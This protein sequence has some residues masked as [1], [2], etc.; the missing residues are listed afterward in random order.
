MTD[1]ID[2]AARR[3]LLG[4]IE[5][6]IRECQK[7]IK[8]VLAHLDEF[9]VDVAT[10]FHLDRLESY[11]S[12]L[13]S[14][15]SLVLGGSR[16]SGAILAFIAE[17][18][19]E[20]VKRHSITA[21][22]S[23]NLSLISRKIV[24]RSAETGEHYIARDWRDFREMFKQALGGGF[25]TAFTTLIKFGV[26]A[27]SL[28]GF[29]GGFLS[30]INYSLSFLVIQQLGFTLATKQPAMTG[31]AL[32]N[33][34]QQIQDDEG[35]KKL[36]D[37]I[38]HLIRSQMAAVMGNILAVIPAT[39]AVAWAYLE[40]TDRSLLSQSV[41]RYTIDSFSLLGPTPIYAA[42]TGV[43]LWCSSIMAGWADNWFARHRLLPALSKHPRLRYV[44]G[45]A[46]ARHAALMAKHAVS[47]VAGSVS[48]GFLLGLTPAFCKFLGLPLDV[49]HVTL[50]TGSLSVAA[51]SSQAGIW[52]TLD[53]W[54]AVGGIGSMA[55]LNLGVSFALAFFIAVRAR[56]TQAIDRGRIYRA[57]MSRF[58]SKPLS[59]VF[60]PRPNP[61]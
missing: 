31:P 44:L 43:L 51:F 47:G 50:S 26:S 36:V 42:F 24:E 17:L 33:Q 1:T 35:L 25:V 45:E 4:R 56:R 52:R 58:F 11:L 55:I 2:E 34:L 48:L 6:K 54:L 53:F 5:V 18:V 28:P 46:G 32:A 21:L 30:S 38:T 14:L 13:R 19:S 49:R 16:E 61:S 59:F 60:P 15:C 12:R 27:V 37:E 57:V 41:A 7:C 23:E 20:N 3:E 9:G 10:V 29:V 39:A 40:L 8:E 22:F